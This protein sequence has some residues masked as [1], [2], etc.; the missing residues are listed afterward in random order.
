MTPLRTLSAALVLAVIAWP[1][2][3]LAQETLPAEPGWA[4]VLPPLTAIAMALIFRQVI[5]ALF[6]GVWFGAVMLR[7]VTLPNVWFGL[8]DTLEVHVLSQLADSGNASVILFTLMIGGMVGIVSRNGGLQGLVEHV[9]RWASS[10]RRAC[11]ATAGLG[12]AIFFDD[13]ANTLV[14]GNTMRS[15]TD[16]MRVSRAKLA[17]IVDSTAAPVACIALVTTWIGYEVGL[18][19]DAT[20]SLP[21]FDQQP[22]LVF[23]NTIPYSFYPILAIALVFL[24][25]LSG[26]DFGPMHA[27]EQHVR[28]HGVLA[29]DARA[30]GA[31]PDCEPIPPVDDRPHRAVNAIVPVLVLVGGVMVGL[32]VDGRGN[33]EGPGASVQDIIGAADPYRALLWASLLGVLVAA[34][35]SMG[36]RL[37][38]MGEVVDAWYRGVRTMLFAMVILVL[39]WALGAV[40]ESLGTAQYLSELLRGSIPVTALPALIFVI[41][42][43]TA[44]ATGTSWGVMAILFP[45]T[46]PLSWTMMQAQGFSDPAD[47]HIFYSGIASV[48]AGAVW[49]DHCS[50]ISDTTIL[51][52]MASGCDH[53]EHVRTQLP[54]ALLAGFTAILT[55]SLPVAW[56]LPWWA[57]LGIGG[58]VLVIAVL[59]F[60]RV[61]PVHNTH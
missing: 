57:G 61:Q 54:Y 11:V 27:A 10:A 49:G 35:L 52:S 45:L 16:E 44:F 9:A 5:P 46:I 47:L 15:I 56:G 25:V 4:S 26:R 42:A 40:T 23:L 20:A 34:A 29:E 38:S 28:Q 31:A 51:S 18:I 8:L 41:A 17:Y 13:Y 24:I 53:I 3:V 58:A 59:V 21:G 22:Y 33:V 55:C 50:P 36:Q 30:E 37:L 2:A 60:G 1:L 6:V 19:G 7:G 39:A 48:L 14:V 43:A 32:Y 12:L